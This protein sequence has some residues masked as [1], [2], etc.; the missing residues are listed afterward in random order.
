MEDLNDFIFSSDTAFSVKAIKTFHFQYHNN[1]I[2]KRFADSLNYNLPLIKTI[3]QIPFL[4]ISFF[5][6]HKI[7][8]T[9]FAPQSIF[10]SSGTTNVG[11]SMHYIKDMALYESSFQKGFNRFYGNIE[12]YCILGLLPSYLE[13]KGSSL[14]YMIDKMMQIS[15]HPLNGFHL[16]DHSVLADKLILLEKKRQKTI[17][18]GVTY[19]LLNFAE[20]FSIPLKHTIVMETGGMKGKKEEIIREEMHQLLKKAFGV[21][22]IHSEYGMTELL[23]QAYALRD[24]LFQTPGWMRILIR[25]EDDPLRISPAA[26]Q[27]CTGVINVI[28]LA[29]VFSCSF[30]ATEDAG[31]LHRDGSFEVLGRLDNSDK[32]GCSLMAL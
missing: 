18:I 31:R 4:P 1:P 24:G 12:D 19:A 7:T 26:T 11:N 10:E 3:D 22:Q 15:T 6:N 21:K 14:V 8:T 20:E 13:R 23:S 25:E 27:S 5:K 9:D 30:I 28:D 32:R 17:L 2:Y 29:N 16:Y